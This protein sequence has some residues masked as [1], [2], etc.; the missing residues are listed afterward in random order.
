MDVTFLKLLV[1]PSLMYA[2]SAASRRWGSAVG[3][4]LSGLPLTSAPVSVFLAIE[5]GPDF[6]AAAAVGSIAG[7]GA[8]MLS[9]IAYLLTSRRAGAGAAAPAAFA[10]YL[11]AAWWISRLGPRIWLSASLFALTAALVMVLA[12]GAPA[13]RT[14]ATPRWDM[15]A[16]LGA[17]TAMLLAITV[18]APLLGPTITGILSPVPIISWPLIVFA[19]L[20]GGRAQ[21]LAVIRGTAQTSAGILAFYLAVV[22]LV[23]A[24][25]ILAYLVGLVASAG[26]A[27]PWF[28]LEARSRRHA[29]PVRHG[30]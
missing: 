5:Q 13:P 10:A 22:G 25:A 6:A 21:A 9:Y 28:W 4:M 15:A 18:A 24:H 3:G 1:T 19:H 26:F 23:E 27:A 7:M 30:P 16:R 8:V 11:G 2:V 29:V 12:R 14:V 20:Q 17:S